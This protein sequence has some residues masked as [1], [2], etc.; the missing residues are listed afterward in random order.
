M[1]TEIKDNQTK[2]KQSP[3]ATEFHYRQ[4]L[5]SQFRE[6]PNKKKGIFL[7]AS[8]LVVSRQSEL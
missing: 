3:A 1:S 5:I 7:A 6:N 8:N 2:K 4:T